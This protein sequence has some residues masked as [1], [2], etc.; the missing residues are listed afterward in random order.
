MMLMKGI[1]ADQSKDDDGLGTVV[2]NFMR[3]LLFHYFSLKSIF[4]TLNFDYELKIPPK[5]VIKESTSL[6]LQVIDK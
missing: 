4:G 6:I 5:L 3:I 1:K 2:N